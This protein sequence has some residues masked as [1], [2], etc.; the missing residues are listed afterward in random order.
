[1]STSAKWTTSNIPD[2]T[3]RV[4]VITGSNTGLGLETARALA[5]R[6]A[7]VVLAVR[8]T[9][10]GEAARESIVADHSAANVSIQPLDLGSLDSVR[11]AATALSAGHDRIDLLINNA[12]VMYTEWQ[13]TSDGFEFQ[14]GVNHLGHFALTKL[15]IDR[16]VDVEGSR[17]VSVSSVGHRIKSALDPETMMSGEKYDRIAAYGRSKLANLL[18]TYEL[19]RRLEAA[20]AKTSALVAHPGLSSTELARNSPG[21]LQFMER[22]SGPLAQSAAMGAL[23][24]LRAAT[25]PDA[26]GGTYYGPGG[27]METRGHPEIVESSKRSHDVELQRLLW[28]RSEELTGETFDLGTG[29]S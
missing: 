7:T 23:P 14:M 28:L 27:F 18:F 25:D 8:N 10:K 6:G 12:G 20:G 22:F 9:T 2:Q 24:T 15:L 3:G 1:V 21:I 13:T 16:M 17:V 26:T 29:P 5:G 4:A 19:Q 11:E